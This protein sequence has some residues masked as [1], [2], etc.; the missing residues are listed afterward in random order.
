[1]LAQL[2]RISTVRKAVQPAIR[3]LLDKNRPLLLIR[4][5][6]SENGAKL[7]I[8][9]EPEPDLQPSHIWLRQGDEWLQIGDFL[10]SANSASRPATEYVAELNLHRL[11]NLLKAKSKRLYT[12]ADENTKSP[13]SRYDLY[14]ELDGRDITP[15]DRAQ[16]ITRTNN[17]VTF[18][19]PLGRANHSAIT[20]LQDHGTELGTI[21][22][23]INKSGYLSVAVNNVPR[24]YAKITN[25]ALQ[26]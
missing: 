4:A 14:V 18:R 26:V 16:K 6:Q 25:D 11:G 1:M 5:R 23:Y 17:S 8:A 3:G 7:R 24:P 15:P 22:P 10:P 20:A 19:Y 21:T 2:Q 13:S 12:L 9:V